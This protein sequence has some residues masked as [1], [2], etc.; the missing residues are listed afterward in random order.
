ML[1]VFARR[2][3]LYGLAVVLYGILQATPEVHRTGSGAAG[4]KRHRDRRV[5]RPTS[6]W[7]RAIPLI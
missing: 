7:G 5:P 3:V 4:L 1:V 6:P 2:F